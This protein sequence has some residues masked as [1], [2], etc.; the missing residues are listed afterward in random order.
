MITY[1]VE[2]VNRDLLSEIEPLAANHYKEFSG[3]DNFTMDYGL[4]INLYSLGKMALFTARDGDKLMGYLAL[5]VSEDHKIGGA[6]FA[7]EEG[8]YVKPD[9]RSQGISKSMLEFA[10][11]YCLKTFETEYILMAIPVESSLL[12]SVGY[13]IKEYVYIKRLR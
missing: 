10:E 11:Q 1:Q 6:P 3:D 13:N 2:D 5:I 12:T 7:S 4:Y 8:F 9:Y